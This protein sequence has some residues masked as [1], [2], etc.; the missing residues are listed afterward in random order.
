MNSR[1]F[2]V[3]LMFAVTL[4]ILTQ[5]RTNA[6]GPIALIRSILQNNLVGA[7]V[8]HKVSEWDF[9]PEI[10]QKRRAQFYELHGYR[11]D[12]LIERLGLGIDG[13]AEERLQQQRARDAGQLNGVIYRSDKYASLH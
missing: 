11:A 5:H 9:D 4:L 7:P 1:K 10:S 3:C 13:H 8:V 2:S 6:Q 12:K